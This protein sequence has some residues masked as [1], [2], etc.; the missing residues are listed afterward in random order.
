MRKNEIERLVQ[1]NFE[2]I[3]DLTLITR[4]LGNM[5]KLIAHSLDNLQDRIASMEKFNCIGKN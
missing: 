3:K 4:D 2:L 5:V 1:M